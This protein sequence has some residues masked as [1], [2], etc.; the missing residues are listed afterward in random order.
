[1]QIGIIGL[2]LM[3]GSFALAMRKIYKDK[4]EI[5]GYDHND[6]HCLEALELGIVDRV[7]EELLEFA[8][9]DLIILAIPVDAIV[10]TLKSLTFVSQK[11]TI[12]D[13]GSTKQKIIQAIPPEIRQNVVAAHP[14]TGT[15]KFGPS[16]AIETLYRGKV[17]VFCNIEESG[18][19][20]A[21]VAREIFSKL[22]MK[23]FYMDAS[24]HDKHAA[25]ISHMPHA[26]SY[27]LANSVMA[28]EN[29]KAIIALA[30]GGFKD[31]SRIAKSS[32]NMWIDIFRQNRENLLEA[33]ESFKKELNYC[34]KLIEDKNWDE[35]YKWMKSANKLHDIL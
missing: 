33:I 15:E 13:F 4:L 17:I 30:G 9:F 31:M 27:S 21:R 1:M 23:I 11:T 5:V 32:P 6:Q 10:A 19:H 25:Y 20:Q 35:L 34:Q 8:E 7:A 22:G 26:V 12:I 29:P 28:Q 14:M 16:A 2:G 24:E 18:K 3:G